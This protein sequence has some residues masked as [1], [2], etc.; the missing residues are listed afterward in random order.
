[1]KWADLPLLLVPLA[2]SPLLALELGVL[3][4]LVGAAAGTC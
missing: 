3:C 2:L 4:S 1:M